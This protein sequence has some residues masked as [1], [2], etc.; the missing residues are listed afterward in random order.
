M[1][2]IHLEGLLAGPGSLPGLVA[3]GS[4][5]TEPGFRTVD[6]AAGLLASSPALGHR[7]RRPF[8]SRPLP[9]GQDGKSR[10][11]SRLLRSGSEA[12]VLTGDG[13]MEA[14]SHRPPPAGP[15]FRSYHLVPLPHCQGRA[16]WGS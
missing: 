15:G 9:P 14:A 8:S 5:E 7:A 6:W 4:A 10:P 12:T 3:V 16:R 13:C 1:G 2:A 11:F